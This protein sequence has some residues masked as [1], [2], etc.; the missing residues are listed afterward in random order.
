MDT[1]KKLRTGKI[2]LPNGEVTTIEMEESIWKQRDALLQ[3]FTESEIT[4]NIE[5]SCKILNE[6]FYDFYQEGIRYAEMFMKSPNVNV[7][8]SSSNA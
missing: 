1:K 2:L 4:Q 7:H 6:E 3:K 5:K 8:K